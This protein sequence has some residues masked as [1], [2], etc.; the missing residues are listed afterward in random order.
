MKYIDLRIK[1]LTSNNNSA[2]KKETLDQQIEAKS[3]VKKETPGSPEDQ[4]LVTQDHSNDLESRKFDKKVV[5]NEPLDDQS[6]N[7]D[8]KDKCEQVTQSLKRGP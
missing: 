2:A 3:A 5:D 6:E 7:R 8:K 1:P 4:Q